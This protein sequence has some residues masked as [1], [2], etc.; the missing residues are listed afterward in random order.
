MSLLLYKA[1]QEEGRFKEMKHCALRSP[2]KEV[3]SA[4]LREATFAQ[5]LEVLLR[6]RFLESSGTRLRFQPLT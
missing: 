6:E 3:G 2:Q 5:Y 1:R 4:H